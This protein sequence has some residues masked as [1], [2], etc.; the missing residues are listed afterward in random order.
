MKITTFKQFKQACIRGAWRGLR[1]QNFALS[2]GPDGLC[3]YRGKGGACCAIGWLCAEVICVYAEAA[4]SVALREG[5]ITLA[6]PLKEFFDESTVEQQVL[7]LNFLTELQSAHDAA[8]A[9]PSQSVAERMRAL[10]DKHRVDLPPDN[11]IFENGKFYVRTE[12]YAR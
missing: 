1:S 4:V 9:D 2:R 10:A 5:G 8:G 12:E 11:E 6:A 7:I 3:S